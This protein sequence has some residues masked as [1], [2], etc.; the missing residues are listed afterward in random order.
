MC[1]LLADAAAGGDVVAQQEHLDRVALLRRED[2]PLAELAPQLDR[3]E[4]GNHQHR[5]ADELFGPVPLGDPRDYL[6]ALAAVVQL[7]FQQ[8][9]APLH[10]LAV[11]HLAGQQ[12]QPAL[13][14][15]ALLVLRAHEAHGSSIFAKI[16]QAELDGK[17]TFPFTSGQNKYDFIDLD[18][19]ATM[20]VAASVQ[21]KVNGII[22][23]CTGQPR[24]L[25]DRV[26]Q[27]LRDKNYKIKLDYG[28]FPGPPV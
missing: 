19:L 28:V 8:L 4:V 21:N 16:A 13:A 7:E 27:F 14:C 20:I 12:L 25:A 5:L 2:H 15:V 11:Q 18:E 23:V 10:R 17:T 24:T 1:L 22:N 6:A 26:E 9:V 3:F